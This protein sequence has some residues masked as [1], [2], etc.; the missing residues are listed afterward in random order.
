MK[1]LLLL[2]LSLCLATG[3]PLAVESPIAAEIQVVRVFYEDVRDV[4]RLRDFDLWEYTN[5][6][7]RWVLVAA[8][9]EEIEA[10]RALGFP[11][12]VDV[13]RTADLHRPRIVSPEQISGIPGFPCYRTVEETFATAQQIVADHPTLATWT[14][15]GDSWEKTQGL[16]GY[17]MMVLRLTNSAVAGPKPKL[18]ITSSIHAN[19]LPPAELA[20][21]FAEYLADGYG[22]DADATW[23]LDHHE[24]HLM[25]MANPDARKQAEAGFFWRKNTNQDYC[26][27]GSFNRGADLNRNFDFEWDCC[28]GASDNEC[29]GT[30]HGPLPA[31]EPEVQSIQD[32]L[33]ALFPDQRGPLLDDPAPA[34]ATGVYIDIHSAGEDILWPYGFDYTPPNSTELTTMG[35]KLAYFNDFDPKQGID[36]YPTDGTT[37]DFGYGDLGLASYVY[38]TGIAQFLTCSYFE[39]VV[40]P[41]NIPSLTYAAKVARTP[42]MT[43]AGPDAT[44]LQ[45]SPAVFAAGAT[46]SLTA[47]LNDTRYSEV[48]G[49]EP[50][51]PIA[52]AE[53][54]IDTPPWDTG[55]SP[56]ALA[57]AAAD[58]GFD[59]DVEEAVASVD[60]SG[61]SDGR[62]ILYARAQDADGNWGAISASFFEVT[63]DPTGSVSGTITDSAS[64][65]SLAGTVSADSLGVVAYSDPATGAYTLD[66][67]AGSWT[68]R[69]AAAARVDVTAAG[70]VVSGGGTTPQDFALDHPDDDGDGFVNPDDCRRFDSA[71]WSTP[72]PAQQLL[73]TSR[74]G[75]NNLTWSA[76]AAP[77]TTA[78]LEYDLLR[79][80]D[81]SDFE[82]PFCLETGDTD[83]TATAFFNP[84]SGK[85]QY[86]L[87]LT[88]NI[89]GETI[90]PGS[91]GVP[92]SG[93]CP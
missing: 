1:R 39:G 89:C 57:M 61:L 78:T 85:V 45:I 34:D 51:Q 63:S 37:M 58:G 18:V 79:S 52:A 62:H 32:Y 59:S 3:V 12:E 27:P 11:V 54:Y 38:E 86:F 67:P 31:S 6:E 10:I 75:P 5:P 19:E 43:P 44:L 14:D 13:E 50:A 66:L 7:E 82:T 49:I 28:G 25:L 81:A 41:D 72:T 29:S 77:G 65:A 47:T 23:I 87:V 2:A 91:G 46:P 83:T 9:P 71:T 70:V 93:S 26:D 20:T 33:R 30:Y 74:S 48:R 8:T 15:Q 21:R 69:A 35:R 36:L 76:P 53:Y 80:G 88:R 92:R 60:T 64:G 22:S 16:G 84:P 68:L 55:A 40:V 56:V 90:A 42:F 17:D 73:L 24:V 4:S